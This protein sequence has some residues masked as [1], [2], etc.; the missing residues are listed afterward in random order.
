MPLSQPASSQAHTDGFTPPSAESSPA[1]CD[2]DTLHCD[3]YHDCYQ[4][5]VLYASGVE[6]AVCSA[7]LCTRLDSSSIS[8]RLVMVDMKAGSVP[9]SCKAYDCVS[10]IGTCRTSHACTYVTSDM[11]SNGLCMAT[12][13]RRYMRN[14][15]GCMCLSR[16]S[17]AVWVLSGQTAADIDVTRCEVIHSAKGQPCHQHFLLLRV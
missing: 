6:A 17:G 13:E 2:S 16:L 3:Q 5:V 10:T 4:E 12:N 7:G 1:N 15:R 8:T 9:V 11:I 14:S